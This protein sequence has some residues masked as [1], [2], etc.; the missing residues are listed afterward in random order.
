MVLFK[1]V[2]LSQVQNLEQAIAPCNCLALKPGELYQANFKSH[3]TIM[4]ASGSYERPCDLGCFLVKIIDNQ[5]KDGDDSYRQSTEAQISDKLTLIKQLRLR[6]ED[7]DGQMNTAIIRA[8]FSAQQIVIF[9]QLIE[10]I[11]FAKNLAKY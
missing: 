8:H 7:I 5:P 3:I 11:S 10:V 6:V 9:E 4:I 2:N 1:I